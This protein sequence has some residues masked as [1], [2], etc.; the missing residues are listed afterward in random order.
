M[1]TAVTLYDLIP[2]SIPHP[3]P[4]YRAHY[5]RKLDSLRR[6][7]LWLGISQHS[8]EEAVRLLALPPDRVVNISCAADAGFAP[9]R[10]S[11]DMRMELMRAH[12]IARPFICTVGSVEERKNLDALFRA[13]AALE[14]PVRAAHQLVLVGHLQ[15]KERSAL[16]QRAEAC[17]LDASEIV[18]TGHVSDRDL[19]L[20]YN[21]C[22]AFVFPSLHEGFGL[23]ALEAMQCGAPVLASNASSLPEVVGLAE[24]M[25]DPRSVESLARGL[26]S[27]LTDGGVRDR[28]MVHG[29]HQSRQ[30][31]WDRTARAAIDAM[32]QLVRSTS[33]VAV[34][35]THEELIRSV[36]GVLAD[37]PTDGEVANAAVAIARNRGVSRGRQLLVDCSELVGRDAGTGVQRVTRS[38]LRELRRLP[39]EGFTVE[40]VYATKTHGYRYARQFARERLADGSA[41]GA[42]DPIDYG[43][44]DVFL[45]LDLQHE[46]VIARDRFFTELRG[47]GVSVYFLVYDLLPIRFPEYF[48]PGIDLLHEEWLSVITQAD[49]VIGISRD[50]AD[51]CMR[52]LEERCVQRARPLRIG[53]CHCGSDIANSLP[54]RG[55]PADSEALLHRLASCPTFLTVGTIEPR[56]GHLQTIQAFERLWDADVDTNLVI[57]GRPGWMVEPVLARINGHPML[58]TRLFWLQDVSDEFLERIYA[59]STCL[60]APSEGEG[61]GL[62]LVEAA[63]HGKPILVRDLPVFREIA[64]SHAAYFSGILPSDLAGALTDWL[65]LY[66]ADRHPRPDGI[67][68][69]TWEESVERLKDM[70]TSDEWYASWPNVS[71]P[72]YV[73]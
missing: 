36:A 8:C 64:S 23:P 27:V 21:A 25:F 17:G 73:R 47:H 54:S 31:S 58:K 9:R 3:N 61:Y 7:H 72:V 37:A 40:P 35:V 55:L 46:V 56:K 65:A 69:P 11:T 12:R 26:T 4:A 19:A 68:C 13:F 18:M 66:A 33:R 39:P 42:D 49:G 1:T 5:E 38:V 44:G 71:A 16:L 22:E 28:L 53:W 24:A 70:L 20:L 67:A 48:P 51:E 2:L 52:W 60:L 14:P 45:G 57:V 10:V 30:F 63:R 62:P 43:A 41:A 59:A 15:E 29:L 6:A 32:E 50:V 34:P